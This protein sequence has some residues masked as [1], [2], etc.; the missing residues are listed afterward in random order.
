MAK[1]DDQD[2]KATPKSGDVEFSKISPTAKLVAYFREF[3]DIPFARDVSALIDART[4][5]KTFCP[6]DV[7]LEDFKKFGAPGLEARYKSMISAI[8]H[9]GITQVLE[10]AAGLSFRGFVMTQSPKITYVE[11]DL[12]P[13]MDEKKT[14][15]QKIPGLTDCLNRSNLFLEP[16]NALSMIDLKKSLRHFDKRKPIAIV[17]EGLYQ[18]LSR[19]EKET[20]ARNIHQILSEYG[21]FWITP[22]FMIDSEAS[23]LLVHPK[24]KA[25]MEQMTKAIETLTTRNLG[26]DQFKDQTDLS[27]FLNRL[28]F[29]FK[30]VQQIDGSFELSSL[31]LFPM[32]DEHL[33]RM[34]E[35][36]RLWILSISGK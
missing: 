30:V 34:R 16:A 18:Y 11:T 8:N 9:V 12:A 35:A 24:A 1:K 3:T 4:I 33:G 13:M 7:M 25:L 10:L 6:D 31:K 20:L 2:Q 26:Q 19:Q 23:K 28:G 17:H 22:D 29:N 27:E 15:I 32:A 14:I 36:L 5:T 21:G